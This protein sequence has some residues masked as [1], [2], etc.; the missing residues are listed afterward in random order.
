MI[1]M[2]KIFVLVLF[3]LLS[4]S[5]A[6]AQPT[7]PNTDASTKCSAGEFLEGDNSCTDVIEESEL[8]TANELATQIGSEVTGTGNFVRQTSPTID[9]PTLT[10]STTSDTASGRISYNAV[11]DR[12]Q[13]GDGSAVDEF[14]T[15]AHTVVGD[16]ATGPCFEGTDGNTLQAPSTETL[17]LIS[18]TSVIIG[19]GTNA[20]FTFLTSAS[21]GVQFKDFATFY[22]A[23][24]NG[25]DSGEF[26]ACGGG[27]Y[28][29]VSRGSCILIEGEQRTDG[30]IK[31][32]ASSASGG[33]HKFY[34][35]GSER[36]EIGKNTSVRYMTNGFGQIS[37]GASTVDGLVLNGGNIASGITPDDADGAGLSLFSATADFTTED[38]NAV[39]YAHQTSGV[40]KLRTDN[41]DQWNVDADGDLV[42]LDDNNVEVAD[43]AYGAS[44]N[45]SNAV[46][47]KNAVYD[48]METKVDTGPS[49]DCSSGEYQE[50]DGTC[51]TI[52]TML[53]G[54]FDSQG[55]SNAIS[56]SSATPTAIT[57]TAVTAI[58]KSATQLARVTM[59]M[60]I[61]HSSTGDTCCAEIFRD[62]GSGY[63]AWTDHYCF[64]A[65]EDNSGGQNGT[66]AFTRTDDSSNANPDYRV[67]WWESG[68]GTCYSDWQFLEVEVFDK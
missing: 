37:G 51:D 1:I 32:K 13:V 52:A 45:G 17:S 21:G 65:A 46:P 34:S 48:E 47:T 30:G 5:G 64:T 53:Q 43:E 41:A 59:R 7:V 63:A 60:N 9:S 23:T 35:G 50:G 44:W 24:S 14:H 67:A 54:D 55:G 29:D 18:D 4:V 16:C 28:D 36:W 61:S 58:T 19:D 66:I 42:N 22:A 2:R 62:T 12:L 27:A 3:V 10:L 31:Y 40:I 11:D 57:N 39:L 20:D 6:G 33:S 26:A 38:G 15:G 49:P 25:S 68:S 56:T 8:T